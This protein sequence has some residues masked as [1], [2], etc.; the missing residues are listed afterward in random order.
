MKKSTTLMIIL[1]YLASIV[2]IGFF[3]MKIKVYQPTNYIKSIEMSVEAE[4][5]KMFTFVSKG[6]D[7]DGNHKYDLILHFDYALSNEDG[8]KYLPLSLIPYV[9]YQT[10]DV[11]TKEGSIKY[12]LPDDTKNLVTQG[13]ISLSDKGQFMCYKK[14]LQIFRIY[15]KPTEP[16]GSGTDAEIRVI[17]E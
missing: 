10:G 16:S 3:G 5:K 11:N 1:I 12:V 7:S 15:V 6:Q 13:I 4:D 14:T 9:T 17:I 2:V 8:E